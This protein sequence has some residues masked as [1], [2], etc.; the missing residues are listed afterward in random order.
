MTLRLMLRDNE[1]C[2]VLILLSP[3]F[4]VDYYNIKSRKCRTLLSELWVSCFPA[5][6]AIA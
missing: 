2:N 4:N 6:F 1:T 5:I 3:G